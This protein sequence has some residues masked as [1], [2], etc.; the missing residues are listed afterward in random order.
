MAKR[1]K[2]TKRTT[3]RR[4]RRV[5][6]IGK[7]DFVQIG[8]LVAGAVASKFLDKLPGLS[9]MDGKIKGAAKIAAGIFL[10]KIAG[11]S[12][13]A[14]A[15]GL[16]MVTG[17]GLQLVGSEGLNLVSGIGETDEVLTL[18]VSSVSGIGENLDTLSGYEGS[19]DVSL[20]AGMDDEDEY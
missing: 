10:P 9:T 16:G 17:G 13:M 19:N 12:P 11:N 8:G 5:S 18:D 2:T 4:R 15:V 3:T 14:Q 7:I 20:V 6:G 1:K